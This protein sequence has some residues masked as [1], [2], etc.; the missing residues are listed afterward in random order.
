[1]A[2]CRLFLLLVILGSVTRGADQPSASE[3]QTRLTFLGTSTAN[4]AA[5]EDTACFVINGTLLIDCGFNAAL[6][7][8]R[9]GYEATKIETLF[10]THF[11]HDHYMGLPSLLFTRGMR[12]RELANRPPLLIVGPADDLPVVVELSRRFL[13]ADRFPTVWPK[14]ELRP[15]EPGQTY[16]TDQFKIETVKAL[17]PVTGFCARFT[18]KATGATIAFSGDT[19]PNPALAKLAQGADVL[20]HEAS[21][22]PTTPDDKIGK[23]HSRAVDAARTAKEA[24]VKQ[25]VLVHLSSRQK[26][27]SLAAAQKI[28]A[29]TILGTDGQTLIFPRKI[30]SR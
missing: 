30:S 17:H 16:E 26:D 14:V 19:N 7:M 6:N 23:D 25:L 21:I 22:G 9:Y 10:V 11:H 27:A 13:Q 24:G 8:Q 2:S 3:V 1:M 4:P 29:N 12:S 18:D 5:G 20:I 28:F 15:L